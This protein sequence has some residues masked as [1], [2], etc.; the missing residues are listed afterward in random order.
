MKNHSVV[1]LNSSENSKNL[2]KH[3]LL[4][5]V[6]LAVV[7]LVTIIPAYADG[8]IFEF[9]ADK[10]QYNQ[11]NFVI[12]TGK[13]NGADSPVT[14]IAYPQGGMGNIDRVIPTNGT[15]TH[16]IELVGNIWK[17]SSEVMIRAVYE[18]T[19][20]ETEFSYTVEP[21]TPPT[22]ITLETNSPQ[23]SWGDIMTVSGKVSP[24]VV[25]VNDDTKRPRGAS[26]FA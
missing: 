16:T 26:R 4:A 25:T 1:F 13:V 3:I 9:Q 8:S 7:S 11:G 17:S 23:Y 15:F 5:L 24:I 22:I 6:A 2:M 12:L 21:I 19:Q 14:I 10:T 18:N 20:L